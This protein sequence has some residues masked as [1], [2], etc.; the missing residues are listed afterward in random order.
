MARNNTVEFF[1]H[2]KDMR[3]DPKVNALR[4]KFPG[5]GYSV[6]NMLLETFADSRERSIEWNELNCDLLAADFYIDVDM[7][8]DIVDY[9]VKINLLQIKDG[10]LMSERFKERFDALDTKR[11]QRT[12]A[13]KKAAMVKYNKAS[14]YERIP[15]ASERIPNA[16][17]RIHSIVENSI[18]ENSIENYSSCCSSLSS[19]QAEKE[20]EQQQSFVLNFFLRNWQEPMK[21]F[22]KKFIPWNSSAG[23]KWSDMD[24]EE[25]E[26]A[27]I[28]WQQKP[29]RPARFSQ[30]FLDMWEQVVYKLMASAPDEVIW[31]ALDDGLRWEKRK[32][33]L[34]W[35]HCHQCLCDYM[36]RNLDCIKPIIYRHYGAGTNLSYILDDQKPDN[37]ADTQ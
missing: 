32:D 8:A 33:R 20:E 30:Q 26:A 13:G 23:R 22:F 19:E 6:W 17:E 34:Y 21:E 7:L 27:M 36:E 2:D 11:E 5:W 28:Q 3:H 10:V 25:R 4:I 29:S 1:S 9:C 37:H 24:F 15:N 12:E 14:A 16:C 18:V 31:A 35:L